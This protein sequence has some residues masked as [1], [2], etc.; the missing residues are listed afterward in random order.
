MFWKNKIPT[1]NYIVHFPAILWISSMTDLCLSGCHNAAP[2]FPFRRMVFFG[3]SSFCSIPIPKAMQRPKS[4]AKTKLLLGSYAGWTWGSMQ[5]LYRCAPWSQDQLNPSWA[6]RC[7][8][9]SR[10]RKGPTPEESQMVDIPCM[11]PNNSI[12]LEPT[13]IDMYM[14]IYIHIHTTYIHTFLYACI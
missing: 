12:S 10:N 14:Y 3:H 2:H 4:S 5:A 6:W 9:C 11:E 1:L 13:C 8:S 7:D